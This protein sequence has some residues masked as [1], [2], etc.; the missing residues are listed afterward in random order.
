VYGLGSRHACATANPPSKRLLCST[1]RLRTYRMHDT[2]TQSAHRIGTQQALSVMAAAAAAASAR[3]PRTVLIGSVID[4]EDLNELRAK[5]I[6]CVINVASEDASQVMKLGYA[7]VK[8]R[9]HWCP[10]DDTPEQDIRPTCE[11][12]DGILREAERMQTTTL[13]HCKL[14]VSRS[15]AVVIYHAMQSD[16]TLTLKQAVASVQLFRPQADPNPGF[17]RQLEEIAHARR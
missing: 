9:Y 15:A 7:A 13:V 17:M 8:I 11:W 3:Q 16:R 6:T 2:Y 14:G 10:M 1:Q 4:A 12:V 5:R